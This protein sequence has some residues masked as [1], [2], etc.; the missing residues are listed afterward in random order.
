MVQGSVVKKR[1]GCWWCMVVSGVQGLSG[2]EGRRGGYS[3]SG[4]KQGERERERGRKEEGKDG[5]MQQQAGDAGGK[6]E[7]EKE[8]GRAG[9]AEGEWKLEERDRR[10]RG[11]E[12]GRGRWV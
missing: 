10:N 2:E 8:M 11:E 1:C 4:L 12:R 3:G 5:V 9:R 7:R 6:R